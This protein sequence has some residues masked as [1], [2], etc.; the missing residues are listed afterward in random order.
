MNSRNKFIFL[1][2]IAVCAY[3][4]WSFVSIFINTTKKTEFFTLFKK[5]P[6]IGKQYETLVV[7]CIDITKEQREAIQRYLISKGY[8]DNYI[9][10]SISTDYNKKALY[11]TIDESIRNY[12]I[13]EVMLI[14]HMS[15]I[16]IRKQL[17]LEKISE[18]NETRLASKNLKMI[19]RE[20]DQKYRKKLTITTYLLNLRNVMENITI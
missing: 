8:D 12:N 13:Q 10:Y 4:A 14:G 3:I 6:F 9:M 17:T 20:L 11:K 7:T 2:S 16:S 15:C 5:K 19:K 1:V 18:P